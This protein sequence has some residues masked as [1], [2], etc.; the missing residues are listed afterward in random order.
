MSAPLEGLFV[1][2]L[3]R[4][5]AGPYCTMILSDLGAT[6]VKV[7]RPEGGDDSRSYTPFQNGVSAYFM[8]INRGKRSITLNLKDPKAKDLLLPLI[9]KADILVENFKPGVMER[10]GLGYDE[11]SRINPKIIY[12]SGSGYGHWGPYSQKPSYD[13]I[14]QGM[15]GMMSITGEDEDHPIKVGSSIADISTGMFMCIGI[16][17]ALNRRSVSGKGEHVDLAMLDCMVALLE[18]A[19]ARY[20]TTGEIPKPIGNNHP[21]IAPFFTAE[22]RDGKINI[23]VGNEVLWKRFCGV[24]GQKELTEDPRFLTNKDRVKHWDQLRP[25]LEDQ[26]RIKSSKEWLGVFEQAGIPAGP[27]QNMAQVVQDPQIVA[28]DMM[29]E[30]IHPTAGNFTVP[31]S[32]LKFRN[33]PAKVEQ[34]APDLGQHTEEIYQQ[35]CGC[36][37]DEI[38]TL[39]AQGVI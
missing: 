33:H 5:L 10:F 39:R 11:V 29:V 14:I 24:I 2:D 13:I 4:V 12:A 32:P 6:V 37:L 30:L 22:T 21:S 27:I 31:G 23:G 38:Q 18:N 16:L 19:V 17:A 15:S 20:V 8:S 9:R 26:I 35:L 1:L 3:T 25:L 7:E 36:S 34:P 28:R